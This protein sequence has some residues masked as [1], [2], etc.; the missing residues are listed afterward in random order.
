MDSAEGAPMLYANRFAEAVGP[1][2]AEPDRD[3]CRCVG[4]SVASRPT[5][6]AFHGER[7]DTTAPGWLRLLEL[8]AEAAAEL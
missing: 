5:A 1:G 7:Q 6:V 3:V 2:G 8:I 4:H